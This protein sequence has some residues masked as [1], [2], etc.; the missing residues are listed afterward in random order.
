MS[1]TVDQAKLE[2][3]GLAQKK[4][5]VDK[6]EMGQEDFLKLMTTQLQNQDP[7]KP[8]ENGDFLAQIAQFSTVDGIGKL[9]ES[10]EALSGSLHSNQALQASGLIGRNVMV[11]SNAGVYFG[12]P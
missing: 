3:L 10:F 9:Q 8:M 5:R 1:A 11:P 2:S 4:P 6:K 7:M 12:Q